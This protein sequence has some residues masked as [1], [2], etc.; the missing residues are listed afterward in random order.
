MSAD[1]TAVRICSSFVTATILRFV[2]ALFA[3]HHSGTVL[4]VLLYKGL[5]TLTAFLLPIHDAGGIAAM[6]SVR[7]I[8]VPRNHGNAIVYQ[9]EGMSYLMS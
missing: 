3:K 4:N 6:R 8:L 7:C 9:A 2:N 5:Q 1:G